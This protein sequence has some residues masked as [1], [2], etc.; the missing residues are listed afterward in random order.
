MHDEDRR[1]A[2]LAIEEARKS[3]DEDNSKA[4]P[5]VGAVVVKDGKVLDVA[6]R[7]ELAPGDH[8]EYTVLEK[9]LRDADVSGATV[10]TTLEPCTSRNHPKVPCVERL[11]DRKIGRVVIG[12][13]DPN[14]R[15]RGQ[16]EWRLAK[17][18]VEIG[19]FAPNQMRSLLELNRD[20]IRDQEGPEMTITAPATGFQ[21]ADSDIIIHGT[22]RN[23][24]G[25]CVFLRY[26]ALY[27]PQSRYRPNP[28][29]TWECTMTLSKPGSY[30]VLAAQLSEDLWM[31]V[32]LYFDVAKELKRWMGRT[33]PNLPPGLRV[34]DQIEVVR[35]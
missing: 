34:L 8:A 13:L 14:Q 29:G 6:H 26:K 20:F 31:M 15:I 28:D 9:K 3:Q 30:G 21:T 23:A 2:D 24:R 17:H 25:V 1:F 4:H 22:H 7:G 16:G 32:N 11:L 27:Y 12:M 10:Y 18:N 19:R 5:R 33:M 35:T